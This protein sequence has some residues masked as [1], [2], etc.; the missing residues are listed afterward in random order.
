MS[1]IIKYRKNENFG[2]VPIHYGRYAADLAAVESTV[3][4]TLYALALEKSYQEIEIVDIDY[5][6]D[7]YAIVH[8]AFVK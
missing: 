5:S 8:Y 2:I 6:V 3:R 4:Q 7:S 1:I